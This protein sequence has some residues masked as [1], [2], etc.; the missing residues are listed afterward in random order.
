MKKVAIVTGGAKGIGK[1]IAYKLLE[2]N[3]NVVVW[4]NDEQ[5][6]SEL[7]KSEFF[8]QIQCDVLDES[9]IALS[10]IKTLEL[11]KRV[12]VLVNNAGI[13]Y[14]EPLINI[15]AKNKRHSVENWKNVIDI[16]LTA[17]F[18]VGSFVAEH[19]IMTRINGV[20]VNISSISAKGNAGQSAYSAAKAGLESMTIVWSKELGSFGIRCVAIAPGFIET[21]AMYRAL[22][23][24]RIEELKQQN[25]L[26]RLGKD[27]NISSTVLFVINN[28]YVNGCVIGID[29]G[30]IL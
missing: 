30:L 15:I 14:S 27:E 1:S 21:E 20:I 19:M 2:N 16:N 9:Q 23:G 29:G 3:F 6:L 25:P 11:F 17:P 10:L 24:E 28:D 12:D 18:V 7:E 5:A 8:Y 26:K 4:D 13:I 22:S